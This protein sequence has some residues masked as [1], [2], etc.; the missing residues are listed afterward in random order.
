MSPTSIGD[1][2][3]MEW[4]VIVSAPILS[5][6]LF[7][8]GILA[9]YGLKKTLDESKFVAHEAESRAKDAKVA[10]L[11]A[12][13]ASLPASDVTERLDEAR[14]EIDALKAQLVP[15]R[16]S[17]EHKAA[18]VVNLIGLSV[19]EHTWVWIKHYVSS[20]DGQGLAQDLSTSLEP[21]GGMW[22]MKAMLLSLS[23]RQD[24]RYTDRALRL[25]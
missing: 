24:Y 1:L 9:G 20:P 3:Q 12:R 21:Q 17:V 14:Q 4:S 22:A 18:L 11:E 10:H 6:V 5:I 2:L 16:L 8:A 19:K 15:R 13:L 23:T 7:I 25:D